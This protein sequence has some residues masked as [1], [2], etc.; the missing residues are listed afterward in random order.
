MLR[1]YTFGQEGVFT[2]EV[3]LMRMNFDLANDL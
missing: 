2:N 3:M 1:E